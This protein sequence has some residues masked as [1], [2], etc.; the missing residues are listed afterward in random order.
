MGEHPPEAWVAL[1]SAEEIERRMANPPPTSPPAKHPYNF[2]FTA[3]MS[4][5]MRAHDRIGRAYGRLF[6]EVMAT[7]TRLSR[8]EKEMVAAVAAAAQD[9]HY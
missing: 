9:C 5:L 6:L 3:R 8:R 1:P 2:G 7:D 4:R